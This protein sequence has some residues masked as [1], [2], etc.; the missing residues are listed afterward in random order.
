MPILSSFPS[1]EWSITLSASRD[2][3][4]QSEVHVDANTVT[5]VS[6]AGRTWTLTLGTAISTL[7]IADITFSGSAAGSVVTATDNAEIAQFM[8]MIRNILRI[9]IT[10]E[11][12][13]DSTIRELAFLRRAEL[14][15]YD[16]TDVDNDAAFDAITDTAKRDR[17]R[18][19]VIY[20]TA[21]LLV[22]A[23]PEV[24][25]EGW[26]NQQRQF[27]QIDWQ[28]KINFFI[29]ESDAAIEEDIPAEQQVST[30]GS[31]GSSY[32]RYTAF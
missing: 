12:L 17:F 31:L 18:I 9:G 26:L 28:Q 10:A 30:I 22:P 2:A 20:R 4:P 24:V 21:A 14:A 8:T 25:R 6:G 11:D 1:T 27:A 29:A 32:T 23:L 13:P 19:A 15:V 7:P 5:A 3:L 16:K